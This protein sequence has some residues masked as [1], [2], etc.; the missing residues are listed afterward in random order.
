MKIYSGKNRKWKKNHW[1][2]Y[3]DSGRNREISGKQ[4]RDTGKNI[5]EKYSGKKDCKKN[6]E[7]IWK[8]I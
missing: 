8:T 1:K 3:L 6:S 2:K 5:I 7:K 4:N